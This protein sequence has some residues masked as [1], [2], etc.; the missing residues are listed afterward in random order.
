[1]DISILDKTSI[2]IRSKLASIVVDPSADGP[3]VSCDA[4]ILQSLH[5]S[6]M[7]R[8]VDYRVIINGHGEYEV[9]GVKIS[10]IGVDKGFVYTVVADGLGISL[11]RTSSISK[12]KDNA[13]ECQIGILNADDDF[14]QSII[15]ILEPK[16]VILYGDK[17]EA[18][19]KLL[20]KESLAPI[21]KF[22]VTK[23]KL[24]EEMEV[25]VLG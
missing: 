12:V 15:T 20:G 14:N 2:K 10:G 23:D 1:M 6:D 13:F 16:I 24:P 8:V 21:K 17:K 11:G 25:V 19:L 18:A 9:N 4:V 22:T 3:K 7:S 5:P